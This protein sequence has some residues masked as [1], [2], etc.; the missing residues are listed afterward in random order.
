[1]RVWGKTDTG[2]VRQ[3]NQDA[4][5]TGEI[6]GYT[7][8][9]VCDGMG[10]TLGGQI[11]SRLAVE[12]FHGEME[13]ALKPDMSGE[14]LLQAMAYSVSQANESVRDAAQKD[15]DYRNMGTTLVGVV[16][17]DDLAVICNVGDSRAY[18]ITRHGIEQVSRDHSLVESMVENGELTPE[19]A[20][21]HPNRNLITRALG[22][23]KEIQADGFTVPWKQGEF[24][25]LCSDGLVNTVSDQ[26]ILFE[27]IHSGDLEHCLDR[28]LHMSMDRGAPDN[29]T[30]I[31]LMNI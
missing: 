24:I 5:A 13:K 28:L 8:A 27:V 16:A 14:Q 30:A 29:I 26:E 21:R 19:E 6:T 1:M 2:L 10:G 4:F 20:R 15:A 31:L 9:V 3:E 22:P 17:R 23:D 18:H 11:A 7:V 12:Q 25:L